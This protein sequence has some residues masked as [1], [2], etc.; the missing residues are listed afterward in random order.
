[1][2]QLLFFLNVIIDFR[3]FCQAFNRVQTELSN[4]KHKKS[5]V[6]EIRNGNSQLHSRLLNEG[7]RVLGID[8]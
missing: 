4:A 8:K 6:T 2:V 3:A 1:M 7:I 5:L